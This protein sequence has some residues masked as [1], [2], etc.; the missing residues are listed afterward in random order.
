M[1]CYEKARE[2]KLIEMLALATEVFSK[3]SEVAK[4][5]KKNWNKYFIDFLLKTQEQEILKLTFLISS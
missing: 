4:E 2:A 3:F 1:Y 5:S